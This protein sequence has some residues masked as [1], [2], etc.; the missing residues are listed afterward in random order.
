M[1]YP[2]S[3]ESIYLEKQPSNDWRV[4]PGGGIYKAVTIELT[5]EIIEAIKN[6]VPSGT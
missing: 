4:T 3:G 6:A 1:D 2:D 5:P